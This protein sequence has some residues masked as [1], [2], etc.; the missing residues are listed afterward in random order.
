MPDET[1]T[2]R[3]STQARN[4]S[5]LGMRIIVFEKIPVHQHLNVA[6]SLPRRGLQRLRPQKT[7]Q[8]KGNVIWINHLKVGE[9]HSEHAWEIGIEFTHIGDAA[10]TYIARYMARRKTR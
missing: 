6:L 3:V 9:H 8:A 7:F 10:R 4:I 5:P 1:R 2:I